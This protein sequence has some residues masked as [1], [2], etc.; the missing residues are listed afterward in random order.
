ML[1]L[2]VNETE[3]PVVRL[4]FDKY[5]NEGYGAQRITTFLNTNGYRTRTGKMWH[6]ASIHG[7]LCNLTYTGVLRSGESRSPI[8]P[9]LQIISQE[10]FEKAQQIRKERSAAAQSIPHVPIN[11]RGQSL[12]SGNVFCGHCGARLTLT[13]SQRYRKLRDGA[14]AVMTKRHAFAMSVTE[15]HESKRNAP[16]RRG[17]P[18]IF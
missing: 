15:R 4:I 12:L 7:I 16:G 17:I 11:T 2:T 6:P 14:M 5:V 8:L 1:D 3:A 10:Q 18:Y 13:T 9:E